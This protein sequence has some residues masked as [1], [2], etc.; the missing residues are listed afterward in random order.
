V[1]TRE[2]LIERERR[3]ALPTAIA[4][5]A[6][7]AL[8]IASTVVLAGVSGDGEAEFLRSA[9]EDSGSVTLSSI[10]SA[11]GFLLLIAP[12]LYLFRAAV[13]RSSQMRGQLIGVV[14]AA[15]LFMAASGALTGIVTTDAA[16][17]FVAGKAEPDLIRIDVA[18]DCRG[19]REDL[20]GEA[21]REEYG[22]GAGGG[23]ALEACVATKL[24]DDAAQAALDNSPLRSLTLGLGFG[25]R[26]GLAVAL[27]YSC[28]YAMRVGLLSR[29]WGSLGMALGVA[30]FLILQF[31]L[32]WFIY[33]GLLIVGW[34]PGGRPAAWAA[35]EAVPWPAPGE[36]RPPGGDE[37]VAGSGRPLDQAEPDEA[38]QDPANAPRRRGERRKRKRRG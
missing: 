10:L 22:A 5:M 26:L 21:F 7:I 19:E 4:T 14:V 30:S 16:S 33:L 8:L 12:L 1:A 18:P 27:V 23:G 34:V 13:G 29:F 15:P 11:V 25:G 9:D 37:T 3:W 38:R 20:G 2:Q 24:D 31:T 6:A 28:L 32:I 17:D 35:G 36:S